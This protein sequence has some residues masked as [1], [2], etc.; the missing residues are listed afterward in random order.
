MKKY[1]FL[2]CALF[3]FFSAFA[4][5]QG[6]TNEGGSSQPDAVTAQSERLAEEG[7]LLGTSDSVSS[8]SDSETLSTQ[9]LYSNFFDL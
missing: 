6:L 1:R 4:F 7:A 3:S 5:S 2:F 8:S 9:V